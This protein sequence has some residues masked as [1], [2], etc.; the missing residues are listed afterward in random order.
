MKFSL[1]VTL[2]I[3]SVFLLSV[4]NGQ[5]ERKNGVIDVPSNHSVDE[6]VDRVTSLLK[7]KGVKLFAFVDHSGEA[8]KVGIKMP[9]TKLLIFGSPKAGTPLMQAQPTVGLDLPLKASYL[10][11]RRRSRNECCGATRSACDTERQYRRCD[12]AA[13]ARR[14]GVA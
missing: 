12:P 1:A 14:T 13:R 10:G 7:D 9:P 5:V 6:T 11:R 2:L 3:G 4:A 8:A